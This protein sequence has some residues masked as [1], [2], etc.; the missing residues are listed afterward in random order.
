MKQGALFEGPH[1]QD[2]LDGER[3]YNYSYTRRPMKPS[4]GHNKQPKQS[5]FQDQ[6]A[7]RK[8]YALRGFRIS[9]CEFYYDA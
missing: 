6:L 2:P 8:C 5:P 9:E 7:A 4:Y 3:L 1:F